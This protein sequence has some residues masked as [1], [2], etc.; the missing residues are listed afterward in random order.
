MET[1]ARSSLPFEEDRLWIESIRPWLNA[2]SIQGNS[3]DI[4]HYV[5]T[6]MLNNVRDHSGS[7]S[8]EVFGAVN[9]NE[10]ILSV[11]D[12]GIGIFQRL[13]TGLGLAEPREAVSEISKGKRTTDPV[14]HTGQGIFFS[15][16]VC[17]RF[18]I[19]ANGF[20]VSFKQGGG[21][22]L[23]LFPNKPDNAGTTV[24][25]T[26]M[27]SAHRT[28]RQVFD[29]FCPQ[30]DIEFTKTVIGVH[31]M[32]KAD[33][34]LI[35]R[36]QGRRLMAGLEKFRDIV[37]DFESVASIGQGF[38]D[39]VFRVWHNAHPSISLRTINANVEVSAM[40]KQ[41]GHTG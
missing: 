41:V 24:T 21:P 27:R 9:P 37:L 25:F 10:F 20:G 31:L 5:S 3:L 22:E 32:D 18:L 15:S 40:L 4:A 35:S 38:A 28:L 23:L 11:K 36:S 12:S 34:S 26:I 19:E 39:E 17:E 13:A 14:H 33:G 6:E 29:E 1:I 30:P 2:R 16:K 8:V 7:A